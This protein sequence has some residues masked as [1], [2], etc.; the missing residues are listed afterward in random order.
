MSWFWRQVKF[1]LRWALTA[2]LV[3]TAVGFPCMYWLGAPERYAIALG[4]LF[5]FIATYWL[6][7]PPRATWEDIVG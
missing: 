6:N 4:M 7:G 3:S 2:A 1:D 5:G